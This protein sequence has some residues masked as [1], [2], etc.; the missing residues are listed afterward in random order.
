MESLEQRTRSGQQAGSAKPDLDGF[1][2]APRSHSL[3]A[4]GACLERK[5]LDV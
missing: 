1:F 3:A 4:P 2:G 5:E